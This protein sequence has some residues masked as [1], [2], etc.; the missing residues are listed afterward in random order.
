MHR[1]RMML[2]SLKEYGWSGQILAVQTP[3]AWADPRLGETIPKD[4]EIRRSRCLPKLPGL[5]SLGW[6]AKHFL[7]REGDRWIREQRPDLIYFTTTLFDLFALGPAWKKKHGVRYVLDYQDPWVTDY[8]E[9][10]GAPE[11]PGGRW[12]YRIGQWMAK[13]LEPI[14]IREAAGV[15]A[16]S[17]EYLDQLRR[18]YPQSGEIPM[19]AI[20]FGVSEVDWEKGRELGEVPWEKTDEKVWLNLGR[21]APSM[22]K[23]LEAFFQ[24]LAITPPPKGTKILFL[25]TSYEAGRVSEVD[26]AG[27]AKRFCPQV[28][29][30]AK[31]GRVPL[32]DAVKA[33]QSAERLLF[34]GSDDPGYMPSRLYQYL[35]AKK[36]LLA[37]LHKESPAYRLGEKIGMPGAVGFSNESVEGLAK[38]IAEY[39]SERLVKPGES[40]QTASKMTKELCGLFEGILSE[41]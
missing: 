27:L 5:S 34:F 23:A 26:P 1:A 41:K 15:T 38:K 17:E 7:E 32:L 11:P 6:R 29:V 14:C 28:K 25:G 13:K 10:P 3:E 18:R 37:I 19:R 12:K 24:S 31:P 40:V 30:E 9:K 21:L 2:G 33:L 4:T 20:P 36:P 22:T 39:N 8:Y 16:V 35:Q